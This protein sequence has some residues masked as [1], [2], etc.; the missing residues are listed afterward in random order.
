MA[1]DDLTQSEPDWSPSG[2]QVRFDRVLDPNDA[3][4]G[5]VV[6]SHPTTPFVRR[7]SAEPDVESLRPI[8]HAYLTKL[9]GFVADSDTRQRLD[10]PDKFAPL[11]ELGTRQSDALGLPTDW[12][13]SLAL[14]EELDK[15]ARAFSWVPLDPPPPEEELVKVTLASSIDAVRHKGQKN[16]TR[17]I[18]LL[19][20]DFSGNQFQDSGFGLYVIAHIK[21][22][23]DGTIF[24]I[25][26]TSMR[27]T[28]PFGKFLTAVSGDPNGSQQ[29]DSHPYSK[30]APDDTFFVS[31]NQDTPSIELIPIGKLIPILR[32]EVEQQLQLENLFFRKFRLF[33]SDFEFIGT[34]VSRPSP[35][36]PGPSTSF[37]FVVEGSRE[38]SAFGI[39]RLE[40]SSLV[41]NAAPKHAD[42]FHQDPMSSQT[43]PDVRDRERRPTRSEEFLNAY[44]TE[45]GEFPVFPD[46]LESPGEFRVVQHSQFVRTDPVTHDPKCVELPGSDGL[47]IRTNDFAAVSAYYNTL[48]FFERMKAYGIAPSDM[49]H[50]ATL[51]IR[52]YYRS[53]A[54][55]GT[56]QDGQTVNAEVRS[57]TVLDPPGID[58]HLM[59]ANLSRRSRESGDGAVPLGIA[60]DARWMWHEFGHVLLLAATGEKEFMFAHSSGDA[61]AAIVADPHS[62]FSEREVDEGR[63]VTFPWVFLTRRHD[64][65]VL[66]GW[67]WGGTLDPLRRL[68]AGTDIG[69][70]KSYQAEQILSTSLFRL[71]RCLGGDTI[72]PD[73]SKDPDLDLRPDSD[74]R[75]APDRD[76]REAAAHY[77]VYLIMQ[78][79]RFLVLPAP[80]VEHFVDALIDADVGTSANFEVR[81]ESEVCSPPRMGGCA[82]KLVRWA[83]EAQGLYQHGTS[84]DTIVN[85]PGSPEAVDIYIAD[86]RPSGERTEAGMVTY[87]TSGGYVPVSLD[88]AGNGTDLPA[89]HARGDAI[90]I[91]GAGLHVKVNNRGRETAVDVQVRVW[92]TP[93]PDDLDSVMW[94]DS[95]VTV[96]TE[97]DATSVP[98][99]DVPPGV[100]VIFGP[101]ETL[102]A[103]DDYLFFAE[104]TC[105]NDKAN[106]DTTTFL[107][108]S[109]Q[110]TR[111]VDLV[112]GDNNLGLRIFNIKAP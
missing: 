90:E 42:L 9:R 36:Q 104:A 106:T 53:G 30:F 25:S 10:L 2:F 94:N 19:A 87:A 12:L 4:H 1:Q 80:I 82:H 111:I 93:V 96:W 72:L 70:I 98:P 39:T 59:L 55:R 24:E 99:Q 84:I 52:V 107:P 112:A 37:E 6:V 105:A 43:N 40:K 34:G 103:P 26:I 50:A 57:N 18:V 16:E 44:R 56:G 65:C 83:F 49:F 35:K 68:S 60:A 75:P 66:N 86:N 63:G 78:A 32:P 29:D 91:T 100:D 64:R 41:V 79:I 3:R 23:A 81:L 76:A 92:F 31:D 85:A 22:D 108:C 28:I 102:P 33:G 13:A 69:D 51:P 11:D 95:S 15:P 109:T 20:G 48:Q 38:K 77:A 89:W 74:L 45:R 46:V 54:E 27:A 71:Y 97:L 47:A 17:T 21:P 58:V 5:S 73:G 14:E 110:P 61:L 67:A 62:R 8:A 101:F 7:V 88:W